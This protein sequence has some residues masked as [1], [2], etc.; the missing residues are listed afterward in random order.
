MCS[1][2]YY[3]NLI[4]LFTLKDKLFITILPTNVLLFTYMHTF[5]MLIFYFDGISINDSNLFHRFFVNNKFH[6]L[7]FCLATYNRRMCCYVFIWSKL[8]HVRSEKK[9]SV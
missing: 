9:E 8:F 3:W 4:F 6:F 2:I 1:T 5:L 7:F